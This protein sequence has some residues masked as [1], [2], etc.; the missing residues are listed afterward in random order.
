MT[1]RGQLDAKVKKLKSSDGPVEVKKF[2]EEACVRL[3]IEN[4]GK[5][6]YTEVING[7]C[8]QPP[9][10]YEIPQ[11]S[12]LEILRTMSDKFSKMTV[13]TIT[14]KIG[15]SR[16]DNYLSKE[17]IEGRKQSKKLVDAKK[18]LYYTFRSLIGDSSVAKCTTKEIW[19]NNEDKKQAGHHN[20]FVCA[21]M[22]Y[23]THVT[24]YM[25]S[26]PQDKINRQNKLEDDIRRHRQGD[27][28]LASYFIAFQD[29]HEAAE[30]AGMTAHVPM[31][32]VLAFHAGLN[33]TYS[34]FLTHYLDKIKPLPTTLQEAFDAA[35]M[36]R[37]SNLKS[38]SESG[39][40][41]DEDYRVLVG[42]SSDRNLDNKGGDRSKRKNDYNSAYYSKRR[43]A[44][45]SLSKGVR[46]CWD[47]GSDQHKKPEC[48]GTDA[49]KDEFER[50]VKAHSK[51][52]PT[53]DETAEKPDSGKRP[54]VSF[55]KR[56]KTLVAQNKTG[57]YNDDSGSDQ[58]HYYDESSCFVI[59][60]EDNIFG[61]DTDEDDPVIHS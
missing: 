20:V 8:E 28:D 48:N 33:K 50:R 34:R 58:G 41:T 19:R 57:E 60:G 17:D 46:V 5:E 2:F 56:E 51:L 29:K 16:V 38:G 45:Y 14:E 40:K 21:Q 10:D 11:L 31:R 4:S 32:K 49:K 30:E 22:I 6:F 55:V 26:Q 7:V 9:Y 25:G 27:T 23:L 13:A 42:E 44:V 52:M 18:N 35:E 12:D 47:C 43:A 39:M 24:D 54:K 3:C 36:F 15:A 1:D 37:E 61:D 53:R 59:R